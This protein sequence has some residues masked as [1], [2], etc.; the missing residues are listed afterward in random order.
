MIRRPPRS[1]LFPYTTLFRS[2][3]YKAILVIAHYAAVSRYARPGKS[4]AKIFRR[5]GPKQE[6]IFARRNQQITKFHSKMLAE[7]QSRLLTN[8]TTDVNRNRGYSA[9]IRA[10]VNSRP[11]S[12]NEEPQWIPLA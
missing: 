12:P 7:E 5:A 9:T 3:C 11:D 8:P 4:N 1:T 2:L 10:L 6:F